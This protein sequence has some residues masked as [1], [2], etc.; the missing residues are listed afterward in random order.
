MSWHELDGHEALFYGKDILVLAKHH[1]SS[2]CVVTFTSRGDDATL[3]HAPFGAGVLDNERTSFVSVVSHSNHWWQCK[4]FAPA[5]ARVARHLEA[6]R[7]EKVMGYGGSMGGVGVVHSS[8]YIP[9][10]E[11]IVFAA[12]YDISPDVVPWDKRWH[13]DA[14]KGRYSLK[15]GAEKASTQTTFVFLHDPFNIDKRHLELFSKRLKLAP[16]ALPFAGHE[17]FR[18]LKEIDLA[19]F[20]MRTL[21]L[22]QERFENSARK[23]QK[24]FR[25]KRTGS[26]TFWM[27]AQ[28]EAEKRRKKALANR[29]SIEL[30]K[31]GLHNIGALHILGQSHLGTMKD[32]IAAESFYDRAISINP[33][34]PASWRGKAKSRQARH[35]YTAAVEAALAALAR[36]PTSSDLCR[37]LIESAYHAGNQDML[38]FACRWYLKTSPQE[39]NSDFFKRY[40]S[41]VADQIDR[42]SD[43]RLDRWSELL[44]LIASR[45]P[46]RYTQLLQTIASVSPRTIV[47]IGVFDGGNAQQMITSAN[48]TKLAGGSEGEYIGFDL[49]EEMKPEMVEEELSKMPLPRPQVQRRLE[50]NEFK[51]KLVPGNT[52]LTLPNFSHDRVSKS[53][54]LDFVF[55]DGGHKAETISRDWR[56]LEPLLGK[57]SIVYFDDYYVDR[58]KNIKSFGCNDLISELSQDDRYVIDIM[59]IIDTFEKNFGQLKVSMAKLRLRGGR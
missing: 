19:G 44:R 9:Y 8:Q 17:V 13:E 18:T 52:S 28:M 16:I 41:K 7:Y 31:I 45:R 4:E 6:K 22:S 42:I 53:S 37:V 43:T 58:S 14:V 15:A 33:D 55:I 30:Q 48:A 20:T 12:Q 3:P 35:D 38:T 24:L 2:R 54:K 23:V 47:E 5:M 46:R 34:H 11:A 26:I 10:D 27:N 29:A 57:E 56:N 32:P 51:V 25:E 50:K 39:R 49:F 40:S 59:P 36:R 1:K 21:L